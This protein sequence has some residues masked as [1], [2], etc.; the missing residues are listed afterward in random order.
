MH[1]PLIYLQA[2]LPEGTKEYVACAAQ[3]RLSRGERLPVELIIGAV[4]RPRE[5]PSDPITPDNFAV[6]GAFLKFLHR[7]IEKAGPGTDQLIAE[8]ESVGDGKIYVIDGRAPKPEAGKE[9]V[10]SSEDIFGEFEVDDGEIV[11]DSYRRNTDHRLL[12]SDGRGFF[13]L[14]DKLAE[15]LI[16]ELNRIPEPE[17]DYIAGG[18][19]LIH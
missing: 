14:E 18:W 12:S 17:G 1:L 11:P 3:E 15:C 10:L 5:E 7:I 16:A 4:L 19:E 13:Q 9:W 6:N 8:A 2:D